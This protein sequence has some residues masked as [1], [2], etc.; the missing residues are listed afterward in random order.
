MSSIVLKNDVILGDITELCL[1]SAIH[2]NWYIKDI[3]R[4]FIVPLEMDQARLFYRDGKVI[5][6][7]SWA[8]LS[9]EAEDSF[10]NRSRKL[11][12]EDWKSGQRIYIMDLIAPYGDAGNIGRWMREYLTPYGPSFNTDRA[13]WVRRHP[14]GSIRKL[15]MALEHVTQTQ[16][17]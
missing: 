12:S 15:G 14:D 13:F 8:F 11:Q 6:F 5:G 4:L 3:E 2:K 7:I 17:I 10:L 16:Y 1:G 9:Y